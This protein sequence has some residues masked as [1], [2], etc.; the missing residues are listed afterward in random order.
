MKKKDVEPTTDYFESNINDIHSLEWNCIDGKPKNIIVATKRQKGR[1]PSVFIDANAEPPFKGRIRRVELA[2]RIVKKPRPPLHTPVFTSTKVSMAGFTVSGIESETS[3]LERTWP[4]FAAK[5]LMDNPYD[6][7]NEFYSDSPKQDRK[8]SLRVWPI[9]IGIRIAVRNSNVDNIPVFQNLG[10]T[11]DLAIWHSSKRNQHKGGTGALGDALKR[12][13]KM[14]YA[15][16]TSGYNSQDSFIDRQWDEPI[17]LTFNGQQYTAV[18]YVDKDNQDA[19]VIINRNYEPVIDIG[20]DTEISVALP[21]KYDYD[22][23]LDQ[24]KQYYKIYKIPKIRI[25]FSFEEMQ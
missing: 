11:F 22:S 6:W 1:V 8:I 9:D 23:M 12:I 20:N 15:S 16:W 13:L 4:L 5:E 2:K 14:G 18:L 19:K 17:V 25:D 7:F 24:L 10:L 21:T 3:F